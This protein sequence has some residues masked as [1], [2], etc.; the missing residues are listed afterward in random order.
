MKTAPLP[1]NETARLRVLREFAVLDTPPEPAFDDITALAAHV[2][3]RPIALVS[4]VDA[5]RQW[6]KSRRGLDVAETPREVAFCA[7]AILN[8]AEVM[9]VPDAQ[10]DERFADNP[11]VTSAPHLRFYAGAP[12]V[13]TSGEALGTLCVLDREPG[14]L[15]VAEI[16][17]LRT[18]A[19]HAM[20]QL[21]SRRGEITLLRLELEKARHQIK[22]HESTLVR[23]E[24]MQKALRGEHSFR[25]AVIERAAEGVCVCHVIPTYPF[26][27]FTV[28]NQRMTEITGY[29]MDE[30]NRLGWYQSLYPDPDVQQRAVERMERMRKGEDLRYE[31]WE[32]TH[33]DGRKRA[34]GISTSR[35]TS[36]DGLEHVL[37]LMHDFTEEE[38]LQREAML[39]RKDALTGVRTRRAFR[40][41]AAMLFSLASRTGAPSALGFLDLDD[42]KTVNDSMGHA[43]GDRVLECVGATLAESTRSTDVVG[44]LGGDEFVVLLPNTGPAGVKVFF[45][46]FHQRLLDVMRDHG[47]S[48]GLSVGV[49]V[50]PSA[51]P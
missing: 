46:R 32:I 43:E 33:A 12:L 48:V 49:A 31:R 26:M 4:L 15:S 35:L 24:G 29:T 1:E 38:N 9:V 44:R 37:A 36:A 2:C 6:F 5:D 22:A 13:T 11:L 50:F 16:D 20:A 27:Q 30:I 8:P 47:W 10:R 51:P 42:L 3:K 45:D 34:L 7:H 39:G 23:Q 19:R 14:E 21:E 18:L 28:W 17:A 40:E 25:E 41:E